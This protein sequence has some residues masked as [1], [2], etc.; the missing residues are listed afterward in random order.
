MG[1]CKPNQDTAISLSLLCCAVLT[2]LLR[3]QE[4]LA[5]LTKLV[6]GICLSLACVLDYRHTQHTAMMAGDL[7]SGLHGHKDKEPSLHSLVR[8]LC[9]LNTIIGSNVVIK[10]SVR[11]LMKQ[12]S[13]KRRWGETAAPALYFSVDFVMW[14]VDSVLST[15]CCQ[16]AKLLF[17]MPWFVLLRKLTY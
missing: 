7:N 13:K 1:M 5:V 2:R 14:D 10:V 15:R 3:S 12:K 8:F 6:C 4:K 16:N 9:C 11:S 17:G